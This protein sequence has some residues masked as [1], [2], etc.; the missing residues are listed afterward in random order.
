MANDDLSP[1]LPAEGPQDTVELALLDPQVEP[2]VDPEAVTP[3][4]VADGQ[5]GILPADEV[6]PGEEEIQ[7]ARAARRALKGGDLS[8]LPAGREKRVRKARDRFQRRLLDLTKADKA[9]KKVARDFEKDSLEFNKRFGER[10]LPT[11]KEAPD[12][13]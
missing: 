12:G 4:P 13:S 3:E 2:V 10:L 6:G 7:V 8:G 5:D 11:V 9:S 1:T